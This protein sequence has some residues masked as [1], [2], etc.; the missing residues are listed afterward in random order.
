[1]LTIAYLLTSKWHD[2][3]DG[4]VFLLGCLD[5]FIVIIVAMAI[6]GVGS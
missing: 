3:N 1:M 6:S 5:V 2:V 4:L